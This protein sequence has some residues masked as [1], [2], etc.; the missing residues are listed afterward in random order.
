MVDIYKSGTFSK[1]YEYESFSTSKVNRQFQIKNPKILIALEEA[2]RRLG[3]LN[4][5]SQLIPDID[6]FIKMHVTKEATQSSRIEGTQTEMDEVLMPENE[7]APERKNDWLEVHNYI[8]AM[9]YAINGLDK[10]P[11]SIRLLKETHQILISGARGDHK[12]P[13]EIR[14]SQNWIGGSS[15]KDAFFI[16]PAAEELP[17]LLTDLERFWHNEKIIVPELIKIAISHYQF[18]TIH[19]FLDGN[20]RI[21]RLL[22]TLYLIDKNILRRPTLYLSDFFA[23][24]KGSYYDS[25]TV[26]RSSHNLEQWLLFF[27]NGVIETSKNS[28]MTFQNIIKLRNEIDA[29]ILSLGTRAKKA[30]V[31][32]NSLYSS[33]FIDINHTMKIIGNSHQTASKLITSLEDLGIIKELTGHKRN[34]IYC[35]EKYLRIFN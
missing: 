30:R 32:I 27:L 2:N 19:P 20:G 13:G 4:A 31:L 26:V 5:Y 11:L 1:Q 24:N 29:R 28:I 3:E 34:K 12:S 14:S 33:P 25:L 35:L 17:E 21:G 23:K 8:N 7:I 6:F 18:E 15:L 10:L 9:N 22:I 16:P